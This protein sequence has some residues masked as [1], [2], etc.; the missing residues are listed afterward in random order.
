MN[1]IT[2][3]NPRSRIVIAGAGSIGCYIGG[4]LA[5]AGRKVTL[6]GRGSLSDVISRLGVRISNL[7]QTDKIIPPAALNTT[8][9]PASA[10]TAADLVLVTVKCRDTQEI[11]ALI[12]QHAPRN[13]VVVSLQN[14]V[15]NTRILYD[16]LGPERHILAGT[17]AF[18]VVQTRTETEAPHFHRASSGRIAIGDGIH[19]LRDLLDVPGAPFAEHRDINAILWGKL[20]INLNNALNALSGLPLAAELADRRWRLL[21]REQMLEALGVLKSAGIKPG[22]IEGLHPRLVIFALRLR[23][24]LFRLVARQMLAIHPAARSSMWEDLEA[25]RLTEIDHIQG[26]I[27]RLADR[28]GVPAPLNRR[29]MELVK[30]A[31]RERQ[32]S[33]RHDPAAVRS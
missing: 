31:E 9:D 24:P 26:E 28:Y 10:L 30:N 4:C 8:A 20:L 18:N 1:S 6:L 27:V 32:G 3:V 14:G 25:R 2:T 21:L 29:V 23:D 19:G 12:A 22:R 16:V 7:D 13:V 5:A 17:V 15:N 33:P 11:A